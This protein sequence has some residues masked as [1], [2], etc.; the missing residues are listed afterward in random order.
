LIL[1]ARKL[2]HHC[3][4]VSSS[5]DQVLFRATGAEP[6]SELVIEIGI[7]G[8]KSAA[9]TFG[10]EPGKRLDVRRC[11]FRGANLPP[12]ILTPDMSDKK[13]IELSALAKM[14]QGPF[15]L[16][17]GAVLR[18]RIVRERCFLQ[19]VYELEEASG[20]LSVYSFGAPELPSKVLQDVIHLPG[21]RGNPERA[22]P[23]TA[24]GSEFPGSFENYTAS[25]VA[26]WSGNSP[27]KLDQLDED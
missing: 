23:L 26:Q 19:P 2:D 10:R 5:A 7:S 25:I 15:G 17:K 18:P 12:M 16:P 14:Q 20:A 13:I 8:D 11:V 21:L 4:P 6:A 22:Y 3:A 1:Q 24:V 27:E 9:V